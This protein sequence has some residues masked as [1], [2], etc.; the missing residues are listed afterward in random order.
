VFPVSSLWS[1]PGRDRRG[2]LRVRPV[3]Q[4]DACAHGRR[5]ARPPGH[6]HVRHDHAAAAARGAQRQGCLVAVGGGR[7]RGQRERPPEPRSVRPGEGAA[8]RR[9]PREGG[10]RCA[11]LQRL[12]VRARQPADGRP[13]HIAH[14]RSPDGRIPFSAATRARMAARAARTTP[15]SST[16]PKISAWP[17]DASSASTRVRR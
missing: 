5:Q 10:R 2:P 11:L 12:L 6:V 1:A 8:E 4:V 15:E 3:S 14:H 13:A 16:I 9:V 17:I 7:V